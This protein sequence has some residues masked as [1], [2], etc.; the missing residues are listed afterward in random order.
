MDKKVPILKWDISYHLSTYDPDLYK[1]IYVN[2]NGTSSIPKVISKCKSLLLSASQ[3]T[4]FHT[5]STNSHLISTTIFT[6]HPCILCSIDI[7]GI[8]EMGTSRKLG[9]LMFQPF[10]GFPSMKTAII[11]GM[12]IFHKRHIS[13]KK[14]LRSSNTGLLS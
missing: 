10:L 3:E 5:R 14:D 9:A 8:L 11:I 12:D 7:L 1:F 13:S 4:S 6:L 2:H